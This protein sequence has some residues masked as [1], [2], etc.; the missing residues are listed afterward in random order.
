MAVPQPLV[1]IIRG[2]YD[3]G[4]NANTLKR[5]MRTIALNVGQQNP[6]SGILQSNLNQVVTEANQFVNELYTLKP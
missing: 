5:N 4:E 3:S 6:E 2:S 1:D